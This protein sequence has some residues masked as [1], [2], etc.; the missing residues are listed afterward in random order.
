MLL[1]VAAADD[2]EAPACEPA[3]PRLGAAP[4]AS[5]SRSRPAWSRRRSAARVPASAGALGGLRAAARARARRAPRLAAALDGDAEQADRRAWHLAAPVGPTTAVVARWRRR[6]SARRSAAAT[7]RGPRARARGRA[8]RRPASAP[9]GS[10]APRRPPSLAGRD[11]RRG[12]RR[13]GGSTRR[14][15]GARAELAQCAGLAALGRAARRRHPGWSGRR[16]SRRASIRDG[17]RPAV[18]RAAAASLSAISPRARDRQ[19]DG[20]ASS[21][22]RRRD[23]APSSPTSSSACGL[24]RAGRRR[25]RGAARAAIAWAA[26]SDEP[27]HA[28]FAAR[29]ALWLGDDEA[30]GALVRRPSGSGRARRART[31][32]EAL[33]ARA[34]PARRWRSASPR[35]RSRRRGRRLARELGPRTWSCPAARSPSSRRSRA[36]TTSRTARRASCSRSRRPRGSPS[37]P[38]L[39]SSARD[40]RPRPR[41]LDGGLRAPRLLEDD[42]IRRRTRSFAAFCSPTRSRP[43]FAAGHLDTARRRSRTSRRGRGTRAR[44]RQPR[45]WSGRALLAEGDDGDASTTSEHCGSRG[46]AAVRSRPHSPALR[47][48]PA[49]RAPAQRR[50]TSCAGRSRA[51]SA[52]AP[53]VGGARA[54]GAA[55]HRRDRAQA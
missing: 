46:R 38:R 1:V 7:R 37:G 28:L 40:R 55:R 2:S 39:L 36:A 26:L 13:A 6:P 29:G 44:P 20:D 19:A 10:S 47:R 16:A 27:R 52:S 22:P 50:R 30:A 54:D 12:A 49:P 21:R 34:A 45:L 24:F 41:P 8:L 9:A 53:T 31:L 35:P 25:R 32:A 43:P 23:L 14:P 33:G 48:A 3:R 42:R 4:D 11:A 5:T 18:T 15:A 17:A 51:S